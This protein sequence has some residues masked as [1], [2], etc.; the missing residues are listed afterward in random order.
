MKILLIGGNGFIGRN[1][2]PQIRRD[3]DVTILTRNASKKGEIAGDITDTSSLI[4]LPKYDLIINLVGLS[5]LKRPKRNRGY[6][7]VHVEGVK[8]IID[9]AKR[10]KI[11]RILHF[12]ALGSDPN[13]KFDYLRTKHEAEQLII[14]SGIEYII[15]KPSL[16]LGTDNELMK[17]LRKTSIRG[18]TFFPDI[19]QRVQPIQIEKLASDI[20]RF[21]NGWNS[22]KNSIKYTVG[23]QI[24]TFGETVRK[25]AEKEDLKLFLLPIPYSLFLFSVQMGGYVGILPKN[26]HI[27]LMKDNI[28]LEKA[29][30][31]KR[32]KKKA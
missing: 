18:N 12:S 9:F 29:T 17:I 19:K 8:N 13:S 14:S 5:P 22:H 4:K 1:I 32:V 31:S 10:K 2:L 28:H 21:V 3:H 7:K 11:S 6:Q 16:V 25:E 15:V 30:K 24:M 27:A 26:A 23:E 20:R